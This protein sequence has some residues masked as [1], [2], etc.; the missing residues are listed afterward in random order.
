VD[1][2]V[3][4]TYVGSGSLDSSGTATCSLSG[5]AIGSYHITAHYGADPNF[6]AGDAFPISQVVNPATSVTVTSSDPNPSHFGETVTLTATVSAND[7]SLGTPT[8]SVSFYDGSTL[9]GTVAVDGSGVATLTVS[10][11]SAGSHTITAVYNGDSTFGSSTDSLTQ[12]VN[13]ADTSATLTAD[14]SNPDEGTPVTFTVT[15]A[16]QAPGGGMPVGTVH[17]FDGGVEIGSATVQS[18]GTASFT[19]STLAVGDHTIAAQY[20][21]D[22]DGNF[23]GSDSNPFTVTING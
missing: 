10:S 3:D 19:T 15:V 21:D 17:F 4:G 7:P 1:F 5:L 14:N 9:L 13:A 6:N 20:D 8:G 11:L 18:D 22:V 12:S 16:A 23:N 2:Y